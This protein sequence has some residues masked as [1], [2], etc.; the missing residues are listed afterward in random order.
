MLVKLKL[1]FLG[2]TKLDVLLVNKCKAVVFILV[3]DA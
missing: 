2:L 3:D 1:M